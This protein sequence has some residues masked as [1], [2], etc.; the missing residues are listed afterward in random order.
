MLEVKAIDK[1]AYDAALQVPIESRLHG[2]AVE[3][4]APYIAEMVRS[5]L[6]EQFGPD[7]YTNGYE[8]V[9]TIDSRLQRAAVGALRL[10]LFEYDQR[11]GYRGPAGHVDL[12]ADATETEWNQALED[13]GAHGGLVP[14]VVIGIEDKSATAYTARYGRATL[15]WSGLEWARPP[16]ADGGVGKAP[17]TAGDVLKP[18]DIIYLARDNERHW[19]LMQVP[20]AEGAFVAL[21][22]QDGAVVALSG[23]FDYFSSSFNRAIQAKR[24]PGSAFKPFLYSSALE[25]GFTAATLVNDAPIVFEDASLEGSWRPQ[26]D[27]RKFYGPTRVREALVRSRNLV[28]LRIMHALG[29]PYVIDYAQR[30][31]FDPKAL[32]P[33]L[34]LALGTAQLSPLEMARGYAVFAN[35]GFRVDPY[36]I[37]QV[38][39]GLDGK[40]QDK[41]LFAAN[42]VF[43]CAACATPDA[44]TTLESATSTVRAERP[45]NGIAPPDAASTAL[46]PLTATP[47]PLLN[48]SITSGSGAEAAGVAKAPVSPWAPRAI[49]AQN[50]YIMTDMMADVIKRGTATRALAL[51]R[52][53]I[54]G[55]TGTTNDRRDT[56]FCGFNA[57]LVATAWIGFDQERSL[58]PREEGGRTALPMWIYF[59]EQALKGLPQHRQSA[60]PG[61]VTMRISPATGL[62]ASAGDADAIFETFMPGHVPQVE[63]ADAE[64]GSQVEGTSAPSEKKDESLF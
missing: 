10:A 55:K 41:L 22:P 53:D 28:S 6:L 35:G 51:N 56:W 12:K 60:P 23:G 37:A 14:A 61:L 3:L 17:Q 45:L 52:A 13:Y 44:A 5:K 43:A 26:N 7:I 57:D 18:G 63:V 20:Q 48:A 1:A 4:E 8:A 47:S 46:N 36:F 19:R 33:N 38:R 31:G 42:P 21:D 27:S 40:G 2:P 30:F 15:G 39:T 11:H 29:P 58:G 64:S 9:T 24:Q 62:P 32:P 34:T 50:A 25:N 59:M 54:A 49:S 16:T